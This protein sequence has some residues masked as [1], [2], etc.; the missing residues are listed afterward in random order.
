MEDENESLL[1]MTVR[2]LQESMKGVASYLQFTYETGSD[3]VDGWL[4]VTQLRYQLE[5]GC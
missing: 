5:G 2:A 3:Y 4:V 1:N